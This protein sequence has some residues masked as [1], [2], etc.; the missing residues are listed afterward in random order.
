MT[1]DE[2]SEWCGSNFSLPQPK[3]GGQL[4]ATCP[5]PG[6]WLQA[7]YPLHF[8]TRPPFPLDTHSDARRR[9]T[10]A[11]VAFQACTRL[12]T[13]RFSI[14]P[15]RTDVMRRRPRKKVGHPLGGLSESNRTRTELT[16][17][18][19]SYTHRA[20]PLSPVGRSATGSRSA[21]VPGQGTCFR[22]P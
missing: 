15:L 1:C 14:G 22:R 10:S 2:I 12:G 3:R 4:P 19:R 7:A 5:H 21:P 18:L 11:D 8:A 13:P 9:R 6:H 20:L 16:T 17:A